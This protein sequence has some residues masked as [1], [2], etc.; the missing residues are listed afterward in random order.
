MVIFRFYH[1]ISGVSLEGDITW[2]AHLFTRHC[3]H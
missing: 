2:S 1:V 3:F